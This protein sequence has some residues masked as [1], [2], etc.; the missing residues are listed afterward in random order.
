[1]FEKIS[2]LVS[3]LAAGVMIIVVGLGVALNYN[4]RTQ[5]CSDQQIEPP[6]HIIF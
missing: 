1:M 3:M 5:K 2:G 4:G 6:D